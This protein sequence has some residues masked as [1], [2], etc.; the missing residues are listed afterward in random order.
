MIVEPGS[1]M[2]WHAQDSLIDF[3]GSSWAGGGGK[4]EA[5]A[6]AAGVELLGAAEKESLDWT[7]GMM[8]R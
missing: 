1:G 5:T 7:V 2:F 6:A 3:G 4:G 8:R